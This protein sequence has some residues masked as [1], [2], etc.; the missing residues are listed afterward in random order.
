MPRVHPTLREQALALI[1]GLET[2]I[3]DADEVVAWADDVITDS[4]QP[5][6]AVCEVS[7][8]R[9]EA[10]STIASTLRLVEG[11]E[12]RAQVIRGL[13]IERLLDRHA[14]GKISA[15]RLA[16]W[17]FEDAISDEEGWG[18]LCSEALSYD[19]A[20]DLEQHRIYGT[21]SVDASVML[22]FLERAAARWLQ[23]EDSPPASG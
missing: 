10:R 21:F 9:N 4:P 18:D 8:M 19:D 20:L 2:G 3:A 16:R 13:L 15:R 23:D 11:E 7:L 6:V 5:D 12:P 17:V 1:K 22:D 14:A